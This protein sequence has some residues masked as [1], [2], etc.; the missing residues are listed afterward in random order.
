M[1]YN[2]NNNIN[3]KQHKKGIIVP[4]LLVLVIIG[5]VGY[6][7][8][9]KGIIFK[10]TS[11]NNSQSEVNND[12][13]EEKNIE[14]DKKEDLTFDGSNV[15]NNKD[16]SYYL[17]TEGINGLYVLQRSNNTVEVNY[18]VIESLKEYCPDINTTKD[19]MK[20]TIKFDKNIVDVN[21]VQLSQGIGYESVL[22]LLNDGTVEYMPLC[23]SIVNGIKSYG[24]ING[25]QDIVRFYT[26]I[27]LPNEGEYG[28]YPTVLAKDKNNKLYDIYEI[29][30]DYDYFN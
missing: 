28:G 19:W 27:G 2:D 26:V 9:D 6:I 17:T 25:L 8:Y 11:V 14:E 3:K 24:K 29:V 12:L 7:L 1:E 16:Y 20:G 10:Q 23:D 4:I 18:T 15:E 21:F 5:L 13:K 22:F 30:K